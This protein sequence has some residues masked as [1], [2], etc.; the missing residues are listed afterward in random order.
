M[1]SSSNTNVLIETLMGEIKPVVSEEYGI[2]CRERSNKTNSTFQI[3]W[4]IK[5]LTQ[6]NKVNGFSKNT[7]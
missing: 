6:K 7:I 3:F 5:I 1:E 2:E 4:T